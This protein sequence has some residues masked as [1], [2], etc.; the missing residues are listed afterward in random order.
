MIVGHKINKINVEVGE[1]KGRVEIKSGVNLKDVYQKDFFAA[2][3]KKSGLNFDFTFT[4]D[5]SG[6]GKIEVDGAVFF[7]E[8]KKV[9]DKLEKQWKKDKKIEDEAI[10]PILNRAMS[11]GYIEAIILADRVKLPSPLRM[12]MITPKS[13]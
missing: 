7:V 3:E 2:G 8:D 9:L 4:A 11:I 1:P 13:A 5:Y 6:A 12:P 10:V